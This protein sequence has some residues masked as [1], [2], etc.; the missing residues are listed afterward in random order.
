[1]TFC[2]RRREFIAGLGGAVAWP[3]AAR[4]QRPVMP[5]IGYLNAGAARPDEL[6]AFHKGLSE[7]G[8]VEGRN[9]AVKYRWA[10]NDVGRLPELAADLVCRRVAV[11][12]ALQ[13]SPALAAKTA[14]TTI[15]IVFLAGGDAIV[16]GLVPALNRPGGNVTGINS[17]NY[18][19]GLG[20][21]RLGLLRELLPQATR[22]GL[23]VQANQGNVQSIIG[24]V[25]AAA[26]AIGQTLEVFSANTNREI[27][28]AFAA[29]VQKRIEN[30]RCAVVGGDL[31]VSRY[32]LDT[33]GKEYGFGRQRVE[34]SGPE[35]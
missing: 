14:T 10:N 1:M 28:A 3:L 4:A 7:L 31:G 23:L 20:G 16:A 24:E 35:G 5:V 25:R 12:A 34:H 26:G 29:V 11:I 6:S 19:L 18:G 33:H 15:P 2:I 8:Y 13:I 32:W 27:E 22:F 21:K 17:M 30:V 9:L